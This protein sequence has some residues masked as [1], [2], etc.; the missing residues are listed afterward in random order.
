MSVLQESVLKE[1]VLEEN[2][3]V[4][5]L[6]NAE[7]LARHPEQTNRYQQKI[8]SSTLDQF[9]HNLPRRDAEIL[10][11]GCGTGYVYLPLMKKGY[12]LTGVDL[13]PTL[14][15]VLQE[16]IP[17]EKKGN[18]RLV[19]G[20]IESFLVNSTSQYDG[21][22]CSALLHHFFDYEAVV[23][24]MAKRLAP[25]GVLLIFFEPLKQE[26][27]SRFQFKLHR[28]L[29]KL[30]ERAYEKDMMRR[31]IPLIQDDYEVA[32]YQRRFGGIDPDGLIQLLQG[33]GLEL[34]QKQTYCAR[35]NGWAAWIANNLLGTSNTFNILARKIQS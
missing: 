33:E 3:R 16:K 18:C 24:L 2:R 17:S 26:I 1:Q 34:L 15:D 32:D 10:D 14:L 6:E 11:V 25:G 35:R 7:Y 28:M 12:S 23:K 5:S 27:K 22:I 19:A 9:E 21:I 20:D 29:G 30:D 4:H 8:L 13:S 31:S